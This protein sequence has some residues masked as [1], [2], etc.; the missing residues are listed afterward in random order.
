MD[1]LSTGK[2]PRDR[3]RYRNPY[4]VDPQLAAIRSRW[5]DVGWDKP[6]NASGCIVDDDR[7]IVVRLVYADADVRDAI[8]AAP[9]DVSTLLR[10]VAR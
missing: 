4:R 5:R 6:P 3:F 10:M 2:R 8:A 7:N 1:M 9:R